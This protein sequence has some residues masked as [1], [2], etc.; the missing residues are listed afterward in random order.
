MRCDP[1]MLV[2]KSPGFPCGDNNA[3][4]K[5]H[6]VAAGWV[7]IK[8]PPLQHPTISNS[9]RQADKAATHSPFQLPHPLC[10]CAKSYPVPNFPEN[11]SRHS[12]ISFLLSFFLRL[13][14]LMPFHA[15]GFVL[16][17]LGLLIVLWP[18]GFSTTG[19]CFATCEK[20]LP[21]HA[22]QRQVDPLLLPCHNYPP[23]FSELWALC[24]HSCC[25][26]WL[27]LLLRCCFTFCGTCINAND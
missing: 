11:E 23:L 9:C 17:W 19:L 24:I 6:V 14:H 27:L 25:N 21:C 12:L 7:S 10:C 8:I 4:W 26:I 13:L 2:S 5:R 15:I 22:L 16:P 1:M 20:A 3:V 18:R